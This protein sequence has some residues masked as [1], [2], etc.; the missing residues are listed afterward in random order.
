MTSLLDLCRYPQMIQNA[1]LKS[2]VGISFDFTLYNW[3]GFFCYSTFN[4]ALFWS[5]HIREE[6]RYGDPMS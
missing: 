5:P 4:V 3:I 6:Y 1:L 2:V